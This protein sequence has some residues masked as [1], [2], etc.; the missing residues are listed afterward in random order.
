[1]RAQW[2]A[3]SQR[4]SGPANWNRN[5]CA[6]QQRYRQQAGSEQ[7]EGI[8]FRDSG[9]HREPDVCAR[10]NGPANRGYVRAKDLHE[11]TVLWTSDGGKGIA[12]D[13]DGAGDGDAGAARRDFR[14]ARSPLKE[15]QLV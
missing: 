8:R 5:P 11:A 1:V 3:G 4:S 6:L 10:R 9:T 13:G 15:A 12:G 7:Y 2:C 14:P